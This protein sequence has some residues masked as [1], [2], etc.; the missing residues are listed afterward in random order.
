MIKFQLN[1][2]N[3]VYYYYNWMCSQALRRCCFF[4]IVLLVLLPRSTLFLSFSLRLLFSFSHSQSFLLFGWAGTNKAVH[5][6][7]THFGNERTNEKKAAATI[8]CVYNSVQRAQRLPRR[9]R[10]GSNNNNNQ[11]HEKR[12]HFYCH[13]LAHTRN[14][15]N[16]DNRINV[17]RFDLLYVLFFS[18]LRPLSPFHRL[19]SFFVLLLNA[20]NIVITINNHNFFLSALPFQ[21]KFSVMW[22]LLDQSVSFL[23]KWM[24]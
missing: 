14:L 15:L 9:W 11:K 20:Q 12:K 19:I 13:S 17:E 18:S 2:N 1:E 10:K 22:S 23:W 7:E 24:K 16:N 8:H 4:S 5:H 3:C 21:W 6:I